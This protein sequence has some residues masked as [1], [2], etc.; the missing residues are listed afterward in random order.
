VIEGYCSTGSRQTE[1][2]PSKI[3]TNAITFAKIGRSMKN[4]ENID[5]RLER[6]FVLR[7]D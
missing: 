7:G 1:T 4:R 5:G 2:A 3:V 6:C